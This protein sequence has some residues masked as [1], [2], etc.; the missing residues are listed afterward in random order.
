[1]REAIAGRFVGSSVRRVEDRRLLTGT[2]RYVDDITVPGMLHAA[3]LR[4]PHAH[5]TIK[6]ITTTAARRLAGV[7]AVVTGADVALISNPYIGMLTLEGL[8]EP[9]FYSLATDR[10]RYVGD[11][12]VMVVAESRRVAEDACRLIDVDYEPIEAVATIGQALDPRRPQIWQKADGNTLYRATHTHGDFEGVFAGADRVITQRFVQHPQSNQPMET[13]GLVVEIDPATGRATVHAA[14]QS[15]HA[16]KWVLALLAPRS[17]IRKSVSTMLKNRERPKQFLQGA[18]AFLAANPELKASN[19]ESAPLMLKQMAKDPRRTIAMQRS[20]LGLLAKAPADRPEVKAPDI[21]GAFGAKGVVGREDVTVYAVARDLGRSVKWIE[22]RN[23]HLIGGGHARDE[24]VELSF[25]LKNNGELLGMRA[26]L[27]LDAGAYPA[28]PLNTALFASMIRVMLPGPYRVP[29]LQFTTRIVAS[30]KG[31]YVAYRGPWAVE[32]WVR[33]RMFDI[34]AGELGISRADIRLRNIVGPDELPTTMVTGPPLDVRMSA[35]RTLTDALEIA[36]FD[37]WQSVQAAARAE[38]RILGLGLATYIEAAP[39]P[40]GYMNY[41]MPGF[42]AIAGAE[43][44]FVTLDADGGVS[45]FTQQVPHGQGHETTLAQVAADQLGVAI[46]S[47]RVRY[48]DTT[49]APFGIIGTGGSRAAA[50]AGGVVTFAAGELRERIL[51]IAADLMEAGRD[52]IVIENGLVHVA[53][54]PARGIGFPAIASEAIRR[55]STAPNGEAIRVTHRYDG[56]EGGWS[57][58]THVCWVEIDLET[59]VVAIPRYVVVEDCGQLINPAIVE[60][61]VRGGVA[62]GIG[63]VLY[64]KISYDDSGQFRTGTFMDYL[65][66]TAMEIPQIEIHHVETPSDIEANYRGVGEGG[67]IAAPAAL[68][69]A[70]ED[71]LKHLGVRIVEQYLPPS[72]I[73]ELARVIPTS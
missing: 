38:G 68:T 46:E 20:L 12:V 2:G 69:N 11:P 21:G 15:A 29:A 25:A 49:T 23:E 52:D 9:S 6:T 7:V 58:A 40:P 48:G 65:I 51:D 27:V 71:A 37:E 66:P 18:K 36:E 44:A 33:E 39:G 70:I 60:G 13:R 54:V 62:Q 45:V 10:V 17:G 5:A 24:Q 35:K 16:Y 19:K 22:D 3:F 64:E 8:Y 41:V 30:N 53:G 50:M 34:C 26:D 47:V 1:M 32:T 61:Q 56:G 73:L 14:T 67:M 28:V 43:P 42:G 57:Q 31:A 63:A 59:G 4:S 72:R 55:G